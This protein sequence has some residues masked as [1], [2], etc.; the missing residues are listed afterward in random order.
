LDPAP[1]MK[2]SKRVSKSVHERPKSC[3]SPSGEGKAGAQ[4]FYGVLLRNGEG[5]SKNGVEA[6]RYL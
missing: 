5:L 4:Y 3:N 6:V 1:T 2:V